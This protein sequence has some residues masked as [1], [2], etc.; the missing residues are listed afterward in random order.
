MDFD[1]QQLQI[2]DETFTS[3]GYLCSHHFCTVKHLALVCNTL[4]CGNI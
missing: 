4:K 1:L 2:R 3:C